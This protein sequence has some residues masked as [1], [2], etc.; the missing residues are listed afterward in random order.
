MNLLI[1]RRNIKPFKGMTRRW[2]IRLE[3]KPQD[4]WVGVFWKRSGKFRG[5]FDE[6]PYLDVWVCMVPM[7]PIHYGWKPQVRHG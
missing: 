2:F 1:F 7:L 6:N 4:C 5:R 3:W